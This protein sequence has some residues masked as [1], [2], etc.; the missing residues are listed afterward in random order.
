MSW[1]NKK[2]ILYFILTFAA[3]VG[4][5]LFQVYSAQNLTIAEYGMFNSWLAELSVFLFCG[6]F[7]QYFANLS[8]LTTLQLRLVLAG[9]F[10]AVLIMGFVFFYSNQMSTTTPAQAFVLS[11]ASSLIFSYLFGVT[12]IQLGFVAMG[13]SGFLVAL[14][15][16]AYPFFHSSAS[17]SFYQALPFSYLVGILFLVVYLSKQK[18]YGGAK[19]ISMSL[20]AALTLSIATVLIPQM[21]ILV[22]KYTQ[23]EDVIGRFSYI[24]L[25]Y[26]GF[27]FLFMIVSQWFLPQQVRQT[28]FSNRKYETHRNLIVIILIGLGAGALTSV[29]FPILVDVILHKQIEV[30][31]NWIVFSFLHISL[32]TYLFYF[33][34]TYCTQQQLLKAGI[35]VSTNVVCLLVFSF[36]TI[37]VLQY[38]I[39]VCAIE[40]V[41]LFLT[42]LSSEKLQANG[43]KV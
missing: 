17:F 10:V 30:E 20:G 22:V 8:S 39:S 25:F 7:L 40:I 21:D 34:Q 24:S 35:L 11:F 9:S 42:T 3:G 26:K 29:L 38:L 33:V 14:S 36:M 31:K 5:Y 15:K 37:S 18:S 4:H 6:V 2:N 13:V 28:A 32:L 23:N 27:F 12:Q 1:L 43:H 16:W 19:K 41:L